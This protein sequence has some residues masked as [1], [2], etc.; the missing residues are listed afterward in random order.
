[1]STVDRQPDAPAELCARSP[2]TDRIL[3]AAEGFA[4]IT[5]QAEYRT[6]QF[7]RQ[8][9]DLRRRQMVSDLG[10]SAAPTVAT[11]ASHQAPAGLGHSASVNLREASDA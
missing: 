8:W 6:A 10:A 5:R 7:E 1:M 3:E 11:R 4:A 2:Y 9:N